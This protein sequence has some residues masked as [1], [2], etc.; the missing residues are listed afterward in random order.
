MARDK[1][2]YKE[3]KEPYIELDNNANNK[4]EVKM[5]YELLMMYCYMF[6]GIIFWHNFWNWNLLWA[7]LLMFIGKF[8][9]EFK[10]KSMY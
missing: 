9:C 1:I 7:V 6:A 4:M 10:I 5:F 2:V 8:I 3:G